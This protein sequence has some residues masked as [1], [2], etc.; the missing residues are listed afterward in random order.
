M[1]NGCSRKLLTPSGKI[2]R[3]FKLS[4]TTDRLLRKKATK[5]KR[6]QTALLES[7]IETCCC[8][9]GEPIILTAKA[10]RLVAQAAKR[11]G[12]DPMRILEECII[13]AMT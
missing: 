5:E 3:N 7:F 13:S 2:H 9:V 4:A 10:Q 11:Q 8:K 12:K 1:L 6:N